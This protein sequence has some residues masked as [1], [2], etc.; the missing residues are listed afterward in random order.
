MVVGYLSYTM[1]FYFVGELRRVRLYFE[2]KNPIELEVNLL[3]Y[4]RWIYMVCGASST[5]LIGMTVLILTE[6]L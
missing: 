4:R 2:S 1:Q 6:E 5:A 3:K